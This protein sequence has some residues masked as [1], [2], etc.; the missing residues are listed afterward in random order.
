M[1]LMNSMFFAPLDVYEPAGMFT[2]QDIMSL[3]ICLIL[4]SLALIA[5]K[6]IKWQTVL[7]ITKVMTCLEVIKNGTTFIT[8]TLS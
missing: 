5:S 6:K 8:V 4:V 2:T 3:I 7:L 1:K